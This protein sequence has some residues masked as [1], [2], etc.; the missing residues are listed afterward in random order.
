[1]LLILLH[2]L[3]KRDQ[4]N[5]ACSKFNL[6]DG[7]SLYYMVLLLLRLSITEARRIGGYYFYK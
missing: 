1:M 4:K 5:S 6:E 7:A 2:I 3:G